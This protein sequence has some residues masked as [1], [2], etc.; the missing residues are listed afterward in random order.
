MIEQYESA[1]ASSP[2]TSAGDTTGSGSSKS[3]NSGGGGNSDTPIGP[4][5][6]GIVGG[7]VLLGIIAF[8]LFLIF[9]QRRRNADDAAYSRKGQDTLGSELAPGVSVAAM[10]SYGGLR[11]PSPQRSYDNFPVQNGAGMG[12]G[13]AYS[14]GAAAGM[15]GA[16]SS[17]HP[18]R[19]P[20]ATQYGQ[21]Y[22]SGGSSPNQFIAGGA[23]NGGGPEMDMPPPDYDR[24]FSPVGSS[25]SGS[26]PAPDS[27]VGGSAWYGPGPASSVTS[28]SG[29]SAAM[30]GPTGG[31]I[32]G[33]PPPNPA[34]TRVYRQ[35]QEKGI[36]IP[37]NRDVGVNRMQ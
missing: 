13:L 12:N 33:L 11:G 10:A 27:S 35:L 9:R 29:G 26:Q 36:P 32:G 16:S 21:A 20:M 34:E 19:S 6:G 25:V 18:G 28:A 37:A 7:L 23:R 30:G 5:V 3:G 14:P 17:M 1:P 4:I 8:L 24:V 22:A 31:V 15:A 2:G